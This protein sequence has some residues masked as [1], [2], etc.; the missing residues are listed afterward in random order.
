[1]NDNGDLGVQ[2]LMREIDRE[3][4][5]QELAKREFKRNKHLAI[6]A[7]LEMFVTTSTMMLNN[8]ITTPPRSDDDFQPTLVEYE[9]LR[10]Y[11]NDSLLNVSRMKSCSV[12]QFGP[13]WEW[14]PF[15]KAPPKVRVPKDKKKGSKEEDSL[16]E[17]I[18]ISDDEE[19]TEEQAAKKKEEAEAAKKKA[20]EVK[21]KRAEALKKA[22]EAAKAKKDA[23]A[24]QTTGLIGETTPNA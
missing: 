5:K 6:R 20:E 13:T 21:K 10:L 9:N 22:R 2:Y 11:V 12:P 16:T 3:V 15:N 17:V 1:V 23:A 8:M 7:V 4:M 18:E 19:M 24:A 14:K